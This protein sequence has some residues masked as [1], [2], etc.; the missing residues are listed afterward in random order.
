M[1]FLLNNNNNMLANNN[2]HVY[3]HKGA[4]K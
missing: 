2:E 4:N 1:D 3:S